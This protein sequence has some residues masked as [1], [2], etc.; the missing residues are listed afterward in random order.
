LERLR[1]AK[2][3]VRVAKFALI[4]RVSCEKASFGGGV[5][6]DKDEN[7]KAMQSQRLPLERDGL[8]AFTCKSTSSVCFLQLR[9][10]PW[11]RA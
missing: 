5:P 7:R 9:P 8:V 6:P 1:S 2:I 4:K 3:F 11:G 10:L